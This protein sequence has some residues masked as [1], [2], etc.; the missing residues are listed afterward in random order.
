MTAV[1]ST[2]PAP[3]ITLDPTGARLYAQ[4][5]QLRAAGPAVPVALPGG[6]TAW[7]VTRGDLVRKL[8]TDP[9]VSKDARRSRPGHRPFAVPWLAAWVDVISMFTTDDA[10]HDRLRSLV[11]Q[12]FTPRRVEAL[13]PA[14]E[15][16]VQD[17]LDDLDG[18]PPGATVDL[19]AAFGHRVPTE[20]ICRLF[21]VPV[22]Q[23]P[24]MLAV[25]DSCSSRPPL[26]TRRPRTSPPACTRPCTG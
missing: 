9:R 13:R 2:P 18:R 12:A 10:Q 15:T 26:P 7:S 20:V 5:D 16:I 4:A 19:R 17:L 21:G 6:L 3:A 8:A 25:I 11:S 14:V 22:E 23:R 1:P 24:A